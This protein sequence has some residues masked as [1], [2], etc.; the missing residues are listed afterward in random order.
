MEKIQRYFTRCL[1]F[2]FHIHNLSYIQRLQR[3]KLDPLELRRLRIDLSMCYKIVHGD[4][5][6]GMLSVFQI[7]SDSRTRG[8]ALKLRL[9]H[10]RLDCFKYD[11]FSRIKSVWNDL[12]GFVRDRPLVFAMNVSVF[13]QLL[14]SVD[15][16]R[17]MKFDRNLD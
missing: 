15:L 17:Y 3:F 7:V 4:I 14:Q 5:G 9:N 11:Y 6:N 13:K 8:H 16:S 1:A 12:P 10:S 2:R